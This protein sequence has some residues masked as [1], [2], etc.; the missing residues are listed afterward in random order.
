M[1]ISFEQ[2][3]LGSKIEFNKEAGTLILWGL[4]TQLRDQLKR[5]SA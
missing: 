5:A 2:H 1:S 3:L 4:L